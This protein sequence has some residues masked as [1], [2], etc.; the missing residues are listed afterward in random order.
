MNKPLDLDRLIVNLPLAAVLEIAAAGTY[1]LVVAPVR[2]W[3]R[4][5]DEQV[6]VRPA[7]K[8]AA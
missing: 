1:A 3:V 4:A 6:T 7:A 8:R 2:T 5:G